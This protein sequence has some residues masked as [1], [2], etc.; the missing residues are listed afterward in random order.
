MN[1][2]EFEWDDAKAAANLAKHKV[3]FEQA[4]E[5]FRDV[6]SVEREDDTQAY[7]EPRHTLLGMVGDRLLFVAYTMRGDITRIISARGAEPHERRLYHE[8]NSD[9]A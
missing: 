4:R 8:D 1:D 9:Q 7:D 6:F 3:S 2:D 5:A